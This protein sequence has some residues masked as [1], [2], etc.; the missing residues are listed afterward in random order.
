MKL[1]SILTAALNIS[2]GYVLVTV[3]HSSYQT[4][5]GMDIKSSSY[6]LLIISFQTP[7]EHDQHNQ[8]SK[9]HKFSLNYV[10]EDLLQQD[11]RRVLSYPHDISLPK[12][13]F[14]V[15]GD[16]W[17][18]ILKIVSLRALTSVTPLI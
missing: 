7:L 5:V 13:I 11:H 8:F 18:L 12:P 1:H 2:N 15:A 17:G 9:S 10:T 16:M 3:Q 14:D 4:V 6:T